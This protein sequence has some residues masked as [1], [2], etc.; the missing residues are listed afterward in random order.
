M[1]DDALAREMMALRPQLVRFARGLS[2]DDERSEDLA[3]EAITR[4]WKARASFEP[5]TSLR[6]WLFM[7]LRNFF[8]TEQRRKKWDGG[9]TDDIAGFVIPVA[10][11]QE[12]AIHVRDFERALKL[13]PIDQAEAVLAVSL[14]GSY[15]E[16]AEEANVAEGTIKSRVARGR[17]ALV[18]LLA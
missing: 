16:A 8:L 5:G 10:P 6:A 7:I 13:L 3:S 12:E 14:S 4:G 15:A 11:S 2:K 9:S 17:A 18:G 1:S